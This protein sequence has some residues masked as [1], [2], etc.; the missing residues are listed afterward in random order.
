MIRPNKE[1][2]IE[3][4]KNGDDS[5]DKRVILHLNGS[6]EMSYANNDPERDHRSYVGRSETLDSNNDYVGKN[7]AKDDNYI[8]KSYA[9]FLEAWIKYKKDNVTGQYLELYPTKS[10]EYYEN[11]I[12]ELENK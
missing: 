11:I 10:V 12:N 8:N 3:V 9:M 1:Q 4:I 2:Y 5:K 6:F 7:A